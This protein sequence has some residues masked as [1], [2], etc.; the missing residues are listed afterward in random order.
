MQLFSD[1]KINEARV[2]IKIN[3][4][5]DEAF[6][7]LAAFMT[8]N[9]N[10]K[11]ELQIISSTDRPELSLRIYKDRW[12]IEIAFK[13]LKTSGFNIEETHL[14]NIERL[15]KLLALIMIVFI[16]VYKVGAH[17]KTKKL[18][19]IKKQGRKAI[20]IFKHGLNITAMIL[21]LSDLIVL[22]QLTQFLYCT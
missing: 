22:H 7:Y 8:F 11:R 14:T 5:H 21:I 2:L 20:R 12:Q 3:L 15:E 17:E 6:C 10:N 16:Y 18:I 19:K 9:K 4:I 1:L 13:A